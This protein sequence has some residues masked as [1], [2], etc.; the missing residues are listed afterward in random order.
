MSADGKVAKTNDETPWSDAGWDSFI[1]EVREAGVIIVG[2]KTYEI[3]QTE[4]S[5]EKLGD[6]KVFVLTTNNNYEL[7]S[8]KHYIISGR[9]EFLEIAGEEKIISAVLVGGS[10][11]NTEFIDSVANL[12][13][14]IEPFLFGTGISMFSSADFHMQLSLDSTR[15]L[16]DQVVQLRYT[17][18]H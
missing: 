14:D 9:E 13:I 18:N 10:K 1:H 11:T 8:E 5:F 16:S 12:I 6:P 2:R 3:L 15:N 4:V 17:L 7:L